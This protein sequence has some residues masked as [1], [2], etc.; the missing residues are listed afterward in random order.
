VDAPTATS[1]KVAQ[2]VENI[3]PKYRLTEPTAQSAVDREAYK[4]LRDAAVKGDTNA[5]LTMWEMTRK[6]Q[7]VDKGEPYFSYW[8]AQAARLGSQQANRHLKSTCTDNADKRLFDKSFD[9]ECTLI[10]T[11]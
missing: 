8:L 7:V 4:R 10:D 11:R 6:G 5:M 2:G 3:D 1:G 9:R